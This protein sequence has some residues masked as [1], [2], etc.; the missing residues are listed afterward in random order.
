MTDVEL[1]I[2]LTADASDASQALEGVGDSAKAM[3]D[4]VDNAARTADA[5]GDRMGS[6]A[7]AADGLGSSTSQA[8][9]GLGDLG[10][11][12]SVM[13]GP[14]G[15]VGT[16]MES[17]A[18][19]VMGVTGATDLA[20]LAMNSNIVTSVR[21][22]AAT[23]ANAVATRTASAAQK[24]AAAAQWLLNA[25]MAA[26]PIGLVVIAIAALVAGFVLA[27]KKSE[28]FRNIVQAVGEVGRKAIGWVIDKVGDLV[29]YVRDKAPPV[30]DTLQ[31]KI[32]W[33]KDKAVGYF[34]LMTAPI[35]TIIALVKD[36][37]DWIGRIDFPD[38]PDL[39]GN[40]LGRVAARGGGTG[41]A[42]YDYRNPGGGGA[43][44]VAFISINAAL[45]D[46]ATLRE[47]RDQ[48]RREGIAVV[49]P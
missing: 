30:W 35:R 18:P 4:E 20:T 2:R 13:P 1:A 36:L 8:A 19:L 9:G 33:V 16:G 7:D 42:G 10:G 37:I 15:A 26:N 32:L 39:P 44:R 28:T 46:R 3:A 24:A 48:L 25:A 41:V 34:E 21:Q 23:I 22:R 27:Y 45:V 5:A 6:V 47:L 40:P 12:L 11:A 38:L 29:A 31:E 43:S 17:L 14:L 49:G